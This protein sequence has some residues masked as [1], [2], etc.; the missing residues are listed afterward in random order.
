MAGT[1]CGMRWHAQAAWTKYQNIVK[2]A[3]LASQQLW[4]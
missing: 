2:G 4:K 3:E 1:D